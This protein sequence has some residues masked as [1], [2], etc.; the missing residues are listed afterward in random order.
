MLWAAKGCRTRVGDT[1]FS[2]GLLLPAPAVLR[3][4]RKADDLKQLGARRALFYFISHSEKI[5]AGA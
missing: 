5:F 3:T 4:R 2:L 1:G